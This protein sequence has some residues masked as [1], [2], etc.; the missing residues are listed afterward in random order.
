MGQIDFH[1]GNRPPPVPGE[2][3]HVTLRSDPPRPDAPQLTER[4]SSQEQGPTRPMRFTEIQR[5]A[6]AVHF[7][8]KLRKLLDEELARIAVDDGDV[9]KVS[10]E[11]TVSWP[12]G[13]TDPTLVDLASGE[14]IWPK[15][16]P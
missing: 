11:V 3:G 15:E 16:R 10:R 8:R 5:A 7:S 13:T 6:I 14:V 9:I 1:K 2:V 12:A 4:Q